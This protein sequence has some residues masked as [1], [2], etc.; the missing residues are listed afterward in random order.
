MA[1]DNRN[2]RSGIT[3]LGEVKPGELVKFVED[4]RIEGSGIDAI[5]LLAR[6]DAIEDRL[7]VLGKRRKA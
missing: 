1:E 3:Q 2:R 7:A 6:L 4:A 5:A